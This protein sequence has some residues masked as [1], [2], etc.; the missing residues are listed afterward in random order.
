M[1][2][3]TLLERISMG[4]KLLLPDRAIKF[5]PPD[6]TL[7]RPV[8]SLL[9]KG[10]E[11]QSAC[12]LALFRLEFARL[13]HEVSEEAW[14]SLHDAARRHLRIAAA[15][16]WK[17][18]ELIVLDQFDRADY[19]LLFRA[20]SHGVGVSAGLPPAMNE[21]LER[22]RRSLEVG[23]HGAAPEWRLNL[24]VVLASVPLH[25][26]KGQSSP[27]NLL[28]E[29]YEFARALATRQ[30]TPQTAAA[31]RQL[32][33]MLERG[34]V[35]V[36]AQPIMNLT[37]GDVSGWEILTRGPE[38]SAFHMPDEL[39]RLAS[40]TRL[41]SRLEFLIISKA[42]EEVASRDISEPV[43]LNVTAVTL[44]HP[45]F[46]SH[47]LKCLERHPGLSA[48]QI[49]FEI[50]ERHEVSDFEAMAVILA[51]F[52]QRGFR[53]AVDDAGAGYSSLQW[54]GELGPELIKIDQSVIRHVDRVAVKES[55]LKALVTLAKELNCEVVAEGVEREEEADVLFR[56]DV[57]M[58]QGYYF[59]RPSALLP[60]DERVMFQETK[61]RI[62]HRRGQ[63]AS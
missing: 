52:R 28:R 21:K 63:A 49:Y 45:L 62:Q 46:L 57:D 59:A 36:L 17:D 7:R 5:F 44:T 10:L 20:E 12:Y 47:V 8:L 50:T 31:R 39:F 4:L 53:F 54:I 15:E 37:S 3:P 23:L 56:L 27:E 42:L 40:Q 60:A 14:A 25:A 13:Q 58:G 22:M 29:S 30:A 26:A 32:E 38:G 51:S 16:Q 61:A 24:R 55:M 18:E 33:Q 9:A 1:T 48:G 34:A 2:S 43:F 6:F 41:L 35:S 11:G 19:V